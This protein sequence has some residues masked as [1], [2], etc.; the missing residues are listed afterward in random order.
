M[1]GR[2][3][4]PGVSSFVGAA[5]IFSLCAP[6]AAAAAD[7]WTDPYPGVRYLF[8]TTDEPNEI[9]VLLIDLE[10]PGIRVRST[11]PADRGRTVSAFASA[12]GCQVA[13]N[14]DF[15]TAGFE[16]RGLAMGGGEFWVGTTDGPEESI[17]EFDAFKNVTITA[18][19]GVKPGLAPASVEAVSGRELITNG[20]VTSPSTNPDRFP[21][22]AAGID[23]NGST[24]FLVVVD[25]R[26]EISIGMTLL[27]L[28]ALMADVG[29]WQAINLDGGGSSA[30]RVE[31]AGG[32]VNTP[33]DGNERVVA[34]HLGV[35]VLQYAAA[36]EGSSFDLAEGVTVV[37]GEERSAYVEFRNMG[38]QTW[39]PETTFLAPTPRDQPS[40]LGGPPQW[41]SVGRVSGVDQIVGPGDV[42]RFSLP[43][44]G[45]AL[46]TYSQSF[47]LVEEFVTWFGDEPLGGGPADDQ[48]MITLNVVEE[49]EPGTSTS[50]SDDS[51]SSSSTNSG[52]ESTGTS[53]G[54][55]A[56]PG[57][58]GTA[59]MPTSSTSDSPSADS[60]DDGGCVCAT[61]RSRPVGG[62]WLVLTLFGLG[63][64]TRRR[65]FA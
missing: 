51:G 59:A 45:N 64:R 25:G 41:F 28:G 47:T 56:P 53:T 39:T 43:L 12:Y 5:A 22:T 35:A 16:P 44:R 6:S 26:S 46:G 1:Q 61:G 24:L 10:S 7:T 54:P 36:L 31:A 62:L 19:A 40:L 21:R 42:G 65:P 30:I 9:H 38:T 33:S 29:A 52:G 14:G 63:S 18:P 55:G 60:E 27:E 58:S 48:L 15:F 2:R 49:A 11:R 4:I 50:G 8:R 20:G 57:S 34:N 3:A 17:F 13:I 32:I 23:E 37:V